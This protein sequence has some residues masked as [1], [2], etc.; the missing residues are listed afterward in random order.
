MLTKYMNSPE[1]DLKNSF[2]IGDRITDVQMAVNLG[3]KCI[4]IN[5]HPDLGA[6]EVASSREEL[7]SAVALATPHWKDIYEFLRKQ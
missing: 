7:Q 2:V 4:W 6:G 5:N 3:C 1:Y